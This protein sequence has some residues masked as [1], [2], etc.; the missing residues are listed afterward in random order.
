[1]LICLQQYESDMHTPSP[2]NYNE[3]LDIRL[4]SEQK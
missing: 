2:L 3:V 4:P 1:M